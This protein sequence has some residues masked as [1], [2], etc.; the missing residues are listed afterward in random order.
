M[1]KPTQERLKELLHYNPE[2]GIFVWLHANCNRA[3][4]GFMAGYERDGYIVIGVDEKS[5]GHTS[6]HGYI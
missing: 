4:I 6:L 2:T 1:S 5:M 3:K